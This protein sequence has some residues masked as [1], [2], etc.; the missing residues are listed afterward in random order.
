LLM[1][2]HGISEDEAYQQIRSRAMEKRMTVPQLAE[3]IV[4]AHELLKR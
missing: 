4:R 1:Q 3:E 2:V